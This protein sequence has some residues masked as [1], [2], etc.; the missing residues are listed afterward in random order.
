MVANRMWLFASL[1]IGAT[2]LAT[3]CGD[4][5]G[6]SPD[7]GADDGVTPDDGVAPDVTD[8]SD[9]PP[10]PC[11]TTPHPAVPEMRMAQLT[12]T[13]PP[14]MTGGLFQGIINTSM[15]EETFIWLIRFQG[16]GTGS[17][18]LTTGSGAKM[19]GTTCDYR[20]LA[21]DYPPETL[22]M[23]E[24]GLDFELSGPPIESLGVAIWA[25]G[26]AYPDPPLIVLPLR[27]LDIGG[28][29]EA[30]HLTVGSYNAGTDEWTDGGNLSGKIT[31]ADARAVPIDALGMSLCG[32][33]SGDTGRPADT[34]DDCVDARRP[35]RNMPDTTVGGE[36][37]Y[38]LTGAF[39]ATAVNIVP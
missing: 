9:V 27:E 6:G 31:V 23:S 34:T 13:S 25:E 3:G 22:T 19:A 24:T 29:F 38:S 35:W 7:V 28:R 12:L 15:I 32:L 2:A 4:D 21:P 16:V 26:D 8:E 11:P 5:G 14:A 18:A 39:S 10:G 33:L 1:L 20:F 30:N 36:D 17:I 37:A